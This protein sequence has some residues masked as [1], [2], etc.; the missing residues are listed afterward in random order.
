MYAGALAKSLVRK[1]RL[2]VGDDRLDDD[3]SD[4][5]VL[6]D[7]R[8]RNSGFEPALRKWVTL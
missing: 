3:L 2:N 8:E 6:Y 7:E 1:V 4:G 5:R